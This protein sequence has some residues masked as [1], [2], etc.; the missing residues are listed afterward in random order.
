MFT[1]K[2]RVVYADG[3]TVD[4]EAG[5]LELIKFERKFSTPG[6]PV[7]IGDFAKHQKAEWMFYLAYLGAK[8]A[9]DAGEHDGP[10]KHDF[11]GFVGSLADLEWLDDDPVPLDEI[12][13]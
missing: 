9:A 5:P 7:G 11:D 12:T 8:R 3:R 2:F 6:N 1:Q 4:V 10:F 13:L